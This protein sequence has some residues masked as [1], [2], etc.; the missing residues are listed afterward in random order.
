MLFTRQAIDIAGFAGGEGGE[1]GVAQHGRHGG[2]IRQ[3]GPRRLPTLFAIKVA[4]GVAVAAA[5]AEAAAAAAASSVPVVRALLHTVS[6]S[7]SL[8]PS[9]K[10][11][12]ATAYCGAYIPR[13]PPPVP[14]PPCV[15]Q[16][17]LFCWSFGHLLISMSPYY[18]ARC[19]RPT[20]MTHVRVAVPDGSWPFPCERERGG[21]EAGL[22]PGMPVGEFL[23]DR[24][25]ADHVPQLPEDYPSGELMWCFL[26][27]AFEACGI[28]FRHRSESA[29]F[30]YLGRERR[31]GRLVERSLGGS[32]KA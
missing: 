16:R 18:R 26:C 22:L 2:Y 28:V 20:Y 1:G 19:V 5:E 31:G 12:S 15:S 9:A 27:I 17:Y 11:E 6:S 25:G 14:C 7:P 29:M 8:S 10:K 4:V 13:P 24:P 32:L 23:Q 30:F 21:G 3:G